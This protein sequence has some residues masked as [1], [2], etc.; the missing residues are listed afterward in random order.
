MNPKTID[1]IIQSYFKI[2]YLYSFLPIIGKRFKES[3]KQRYYTREYTRFARQQRKMIYM[4][5]ARFMNI[6][7]IPNGV[8]LEFGSHEGNTMRMAWDAF[9]ELF[10]LEYYAFE[11]F[12]GLPE[13]DEDSIDKTEL[14]YT[15]NLATSVSRFKRKVKNIGI[16][17]DKLKIIE[18]YYEES[19][20]DR[21]QNELMNKYPNVILIDCDLYSSTKTV[22][23]FLKRVLR[24]GTIVIFD[25][26]NCYFGRDDRGERRAFIEFCNENKNIKFNDFVS[27]GEAKSFICVG[28]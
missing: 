12:K 18:G 9:G 16:P 2:M 4:S 27:T 5:C 13:I 3:R 22:L 7:R 17:N 23:N 6:N 21:I 10:D 11:S 8:Y 25:D 19:L 24:M 15:G 1:R 26:W 14:F 28:V 20:D